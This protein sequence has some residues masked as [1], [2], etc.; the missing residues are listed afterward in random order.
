MMVTQSILPKIETIS[1]DALQKLQLE[2]LQ[3]IIAHALHT[4]LYKE[5]LA[6]AGISNTSDFTKLAQLTSLPFT[7]KD[8]LRDSYPFGHLAV[9][10]NLSVL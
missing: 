2:R 7:Y 5:R 8:D 6:L 9:P 10:L 4:K 1:R 3:T